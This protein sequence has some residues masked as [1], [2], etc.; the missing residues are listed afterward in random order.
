MKQV[1]TCLSVRPEDSCF[2]FNRATL[3]QLDLEPELIFRLN[4]R[5]APISSSK[6][7]FFYRETQSCAKS[8]KAVQPV[9]SDAHLS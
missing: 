9:D 3:V 6:E 2:L 8:F 4:S 5:D 1:H 7:D